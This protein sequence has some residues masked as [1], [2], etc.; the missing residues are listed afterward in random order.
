VF[1][2]GRPAEDTRARVTTYLQAVQAS[3]A[4]LGA[5]GRTVLVA[6]AVVAGGVPDLTDQLR[7]D[8]ARQMEALARAAR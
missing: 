6:E 8:V 2:S 3:V 1:G 7:A 5:N 4:A